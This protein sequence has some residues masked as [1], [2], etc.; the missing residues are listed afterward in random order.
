MLKKRM[1]SQGKKALKVLMESEHIQAKIKNKN[2]DIK[3][4][5]TKKAKKYL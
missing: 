5:K 4:D 1:L 3:S 2:T